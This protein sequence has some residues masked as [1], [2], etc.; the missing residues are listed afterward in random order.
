MEVLFERSLDI[1]KKGEI[2]S[3]KFLQKSEVVFMVVRSDM[4]LS[5]YFPPNIFMVSHIDA[6]SR[7]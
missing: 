3:S 1:K 2:I 6:F 7:L 4:K 5:E